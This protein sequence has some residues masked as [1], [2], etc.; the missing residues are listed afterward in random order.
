MPTGPAPPIPLMH[1]QPYP[2]QY[3]WAGVHSCIDVPS[4]ADSSVACSAVDEASAPQNRQSSAA[5]I[6]VFSP[7]FAAAMIS[8]KETW[9]DPPGE[10][11]VLALKEILPPSLTQWT[12][13]WQE[14]RKGN[15]D[16]ERESKVIKEKLKRTR[17]RLVWHGP[18]WEAEFVVKALIEHEFPSAVRCEAH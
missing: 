3:A 5:L 4:D 9:S 18:K 15:N 1:T 10:A 14:R 16:S 12:A 8:A 2:A 17:Q 7:E 11:E 6:G 13:Q